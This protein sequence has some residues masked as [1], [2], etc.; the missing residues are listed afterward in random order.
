[1]GP[2]AHRGISRAFGDRE[3]AFPDGTSGLD[4]QPHYIMELDAVN[5][6]E[7]VVFSTVINRQ[8]ARSLQG[9][10]DLVGRDAFGWNEILAEGALH[11]QF[12]T[13]AIGRSR[14]RG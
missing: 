3:L 4:R 14:Q 5:D 10:P 6:P 13:V 7:N 9:D 12:L 11:R 1:M 2:H 8:I